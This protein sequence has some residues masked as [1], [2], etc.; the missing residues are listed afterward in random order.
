MDL[1]IKEHRE[2]YLA[3]L[4]HELEERKTQLAQA[5]HPDSTVAP[6][7]VKQIEQLIADVKAE[8]EKVGGA[9]EPRN[10]IRK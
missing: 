9:S 8:L 2:R 4:V 6:E 1:D 10:K 3:M 7:R 5:T